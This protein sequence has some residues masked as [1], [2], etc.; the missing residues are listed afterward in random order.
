MERTRMRTR[1]LILAAIL[2]LSSAASAQPEQQPDHAPPPREPEQREGAPTID[3]ESLTERLERTIE[4]SERIIEKN[5]QALEQLNNGEDPREVLRAMR[6]ADLQRSMRERRNAFRSDRD[7][8]QSQP[9][10]KP[11]AESDTER[12]RIFISEHVPELEDQLAQIEALGPN[13]TRSIMGRLTP[14]IIEIIELRRIDPEL[15]RLKLEEFR[16]GLSYVEAVRLYR[17]SIR[18]GAPSEERESLKAQ[19]ESAASA[20]FDILV[21]IKT[22][23]IETLNN[24]V[25]QLRTSLDE[26]VAQRDE[27][28][29]QQVE[30][31]SRTPGARL[32]RPVGPDDIPTDNDD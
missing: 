1:P 31:A 13:A 9:Q 16:A 11:I 28:I 2:A 14:P 17:V 32:N 7:P 30:N 19:V 5:K 6:G 26:L 4:F 23:E 29:Q 25:Q 21:R 8:R 12:V 15:S 24:R 20:R 27:Q 3:R 10:S 22:H 18:T